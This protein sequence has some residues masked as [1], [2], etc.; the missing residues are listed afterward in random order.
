MVDYRR[1]GVEAEEIDAKPINQSDGT[2]INYRLDWSVTMRNAGS[3]HVGEL[4][5]CLQIRLFV[6][7]PQ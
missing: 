4:A 2:T 3:L 6:P 7:Q 1:R 5:F